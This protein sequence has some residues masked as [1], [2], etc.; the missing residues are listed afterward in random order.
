MRI[1]QTLA[2]QRRNARI[3]TAPVLVDEEEEEA[4]VVSEQHEVAYHPHHGAQVPEGVPRGVQLQLEL[5][6]QVRVQHNLHTTEGRLCVRYIY[7]RTGV[8]TGSECHRHA[9]DILP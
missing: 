3:E 6:P 7:T 8:D 1:G 5:P 2:N 4:P 9:N